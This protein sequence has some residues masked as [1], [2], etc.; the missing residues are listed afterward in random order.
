MLSTFSVNLRGMPVR[1]LSVKI[2]GDEIEQ[3]E[4][5]I[6]AFDKSINEDKLNFLIG[7][8]GGN[9]RLC[10]PVDLGRGQ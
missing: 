7:N 3:Q 10:S 2:F 4:T 5:W 9:R 1:S 8:F 6:H